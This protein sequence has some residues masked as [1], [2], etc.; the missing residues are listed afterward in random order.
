VRAASRISTGTI[1]AILARTADALEEP[2]EDLLERVRAA[3]ALNM[4]ET[5]WRTAGNRRTLWG[6]FTDRHAVLRIAADRHEDQARAL[7]AHTRAVVT[8]DRWWA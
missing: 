3:A 8:S 7:L 5:G 2:Y 4:D 1:D 6:A